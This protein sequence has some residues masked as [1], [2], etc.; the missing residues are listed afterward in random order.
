MPKEWSNQYWGHPC[1]REGQA[2]S[3]VSNW[4]GW[5][6]QRSFRVPSPQSAE[7]S[8]NSCLAKRERFSGSEGSYEPIGFAGVSHLVEMVIF[9]ASI[10]GFSEQILKIAFNTRD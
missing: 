5:R 8:A 9:A 1:K 3:S 2:G 10:T 6:R 7:P 4:I